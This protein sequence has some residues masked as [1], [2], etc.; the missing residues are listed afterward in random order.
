M[1]PAPNNSSARQST[2]L[3]SSLAALLMLVAAP[4]RAEGVEM[5]APHLQKP[6]DSGFARPDHRDPMPDPQSDVEVSLAGLLA[7]ADRYSP[8]LA[9]ARSTRS[10]AAA[11]A[12]GA[13][14]FQSSNPTVSVAFGPRRGMTATGVDVE[15]SLTQQLQIAG[16]R[17]QR[18]VAAEA[19]KSLNDAEIEQLRWVVHCDVHAGFHRTLVDRQR[20][21]LA[22][23]LVS[24][25]QEILRVVQKQIAAGETAPLSLRLAEAEVAQARQLAVAAKQA[26]LLSRIRLSQLAGWPVSNPV[27]PGGAPDALR[28][29]LPLEALVKVAGDRLP[30]LLAARARVR[31]AQARL[32][33][34]DRAAWPQPTVGLQYR[35]E[36]NPTAE[37]AYDIVLGV[38]SIPLPVFQTN[39]AERAGVRSDL[40]IAQAELAAAQRLLEGQIAEAR[41]EVAAAA[42][43]TQ[44]YG[45]EILPRFEENLNLLRRA[46][47]LGELDLL[48]LSTGRER[49]LRIQSDALSAQVDYF[50]ALAGLERV[51]GVDLWQD[52]HHEETR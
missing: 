10:R 23:R 25:Q 16:E 46:F 52:D 36:G 51:V 13:A 19:F 7:F 43:R 50:T 2:I 12:S 21:E 1:F 14:V 44:A 20:A 15:A 17:G 49:F 30:N 31:E 38:L 22:D 48:A 29:P 26:L 40:E 8:V 33:A 39:Q 37:G 47:E 34:A 24:F 4:V 41:S 32:A 11:A 3:V 9:V 35:H 45:S 5:P 6:A 27:M 28:E 42:Q 18:L